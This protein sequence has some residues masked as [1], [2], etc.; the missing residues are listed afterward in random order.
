MTPDLVI[1]GGIIGGMALF[2]WAVFGGVLALV[3][4]VDRVA[5]VAR[6]MVRCFSAGSGY[7]ASR[8]LSRG[9]RPGEAEAGGG[10]RRLAD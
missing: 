5:G 4:L 6:K 7:R 10:D 3:W 8:C 2:G 9:Q 1:A